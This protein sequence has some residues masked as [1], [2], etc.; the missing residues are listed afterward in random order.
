MEITGFESLAELEKNY[1]AVMQD[2]EYLAEFYPE[3]VA[4]TLLGTFGMEI[5]N[6]VP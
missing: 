6:S 1:N 5:W 3:L 4:L 2:K